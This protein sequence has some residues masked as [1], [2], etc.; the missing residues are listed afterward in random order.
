MENLNYFKALI[1][2]VGFAFGVNL[3]VT[4]K[5]S[6]AA[7]AKQ[8]ITEEQPR[9]IIDLTVGTM[10]NVAKGSAAKPEK[11]KSKIRK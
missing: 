7:A 3:L 2:A 1:F 5:V 8:R 9:R 6:V 4:H 11:R 10:K